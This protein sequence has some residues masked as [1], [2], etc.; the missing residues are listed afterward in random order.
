MTHPILDVSKVNAADM[1][2]QAATTA[3]NWES[4]TGETVKQ[5]FE[6]LNATASAEYKGVLFSG[7]AEVEFSTSSNS[8]QTTRYAKGR[9]FQIT[10][11]EF[12]RQASPT[13]LKDLLDDTF[14][15]DILSRNA[16]YILNTYGTHLIARSYWGGSAEFNY[17]Y[18]GSEL[19][20]DQALKTALS[21][22]YGK[23]TGEVSVDAQRKATELKNNSSF[24]SSS[25]G[26]NN[27]SFMTADQ[28]TNG[29]DAWVQSVKNAPS[30]CGIPNFNNDLIPIWTIV[31]EINAAKA[32]AIKQEFDKL[33]AARGI[34]L[35]GYKY[36]PPEP[37]YTYVTAIEVREQ[38]SESIPSG[39]TNIVRTDMYNI[40][41]GGVLDAN[42]KAGGAWIRIPYKRET[43][44]N[45]H[46]AIADLWVYSTGKSGSPPNVS[47]WTTIHFDLNKGAGGPYLWLLYRKVNPSDT[48]AI[49]S[50]GSYSGDSAG[51][52]QILAGYEWVNTGGRVDLNL[53]VS[54]KY[55]YL[56]MHKVP[57][58][59]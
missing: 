13:V 9:G 2:R 12:L 40:D 43:G 20:D 1:V 10:K 36:T 8:K 15:A 51:S 30:I 58:K 57:F 44:N 5:L 7:K 46:N 29:Y 26:G 38:S 33:V 59:W 50:I 34:A 25:R 48:M 49:S 16:S 37:T 23:I 55:L 14:R 41:G 27:T 18:T 53:G 47:G 3:S 21:A 39:Y 52:G 45:N 54:G 35:E 56:T 31:A 11:D 28:F 22:T 4:A 6:S 32:T 19:T 24:S 17:S 42:Q